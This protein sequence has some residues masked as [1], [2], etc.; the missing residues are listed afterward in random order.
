MKTVV[1]NSMARID[2]FEDGKIGVK[3]KS[4]SK[5]TTRFKLMELVPSQYQD[6]QLINSGKGHDIIDLS[7]MG[8]PITVRSG[9]GNDKVIG[10]DNSDKLVGGR[11]NDN[12]K[13]KK[14]NDTIVG[15]RGNDRLAGGPDNDT[16]V[17]GKG[18]DL[19]IVG[20]GH[21]VI[22]DFKLNNDRLKIKGH[23]YGYNI[24]SF[25]TYETEVGIVI[26][27]SQKDSVTLIGVAHS[28]IGK[29]KLD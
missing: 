27:F 2:E 8:N 17:G 3:L 19:F 11:G 21:D 12:L 6:V 10:S 26:K 18:R 20:N 25:E 28:D 5:E 23:K 22:S 29:I 4:K 9:R 15:G 1:D 13:G 14:G 24:E 16:Y 7:G